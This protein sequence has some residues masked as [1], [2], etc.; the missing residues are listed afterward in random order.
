MKENKPQIAK[1]AKQLVE[2][3]GNLL[4]ELIAIRV[5]NGLSQEAVG[6]RMGVSQPAVA[7]IEDDDSNPTLSTIRRYALAV[8]ATIDY[9]VTNDFEPNSTART[10]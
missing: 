2:S 7:A 3:H 9:K 8:G 4:D 6:I 5:K 1:R 10:Q